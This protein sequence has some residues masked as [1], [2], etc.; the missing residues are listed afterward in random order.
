MMSAV[1]FSQMP[2]VRTRAFPATPQVLSF[3]QECMLDSC[4]MFMSIKAIVVFFLTYCVYVVN[5]IDW[6]SNVKATF[7]SWYKS[8]S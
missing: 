7:C 5:Y 8:R 1:G 3:C 6:F 2:F 4:Q